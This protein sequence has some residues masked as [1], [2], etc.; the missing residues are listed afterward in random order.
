MDFLMILDDVLAGFR[1]HFPLIILLASLMA[2]IVFF[3]VQSRY[4]PKYQTYETYIVTPNYSVNYNSASYERAALLQI[5]RSFPYVISNNAMQNLIAKDLG[6]GNV[7]GTITAS[8]VEETNAFTITVTASSAQTAQKILQSVMANYPV[9]AKDIIGD[10]T[11]TL[12]TSSG[13]PTRPINAEDSRRSAMIGVI[14]VLALFAAGFSA[15][16]ILRK[17]I[18]KEDDFKKTL[19]VRCLGSVPKAT[20]RRK[21]NDHDKQIRIDNKRIFVFLYGDTHSR[22]HQ[23]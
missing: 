2:S 22:H 5:I 3:T 6:T 12:L 8:S 23:Q 16:S 13:M 18:R 4:V 20:F 17:T 15:A 7:P 19:N 10:T 9:I 21:K 11:L 1:R 14:F